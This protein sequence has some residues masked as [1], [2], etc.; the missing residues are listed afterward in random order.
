M[1]AGESGSNE[2]RA[3][4]GTELSKSQ[5][6]LR[7]SQAELAS[8][9]S[10][11]AVDLTRSTSDSKTTAGA[12]LSELTTQNRLALQGADAAARAQF[13]AVLANDD[14]ILA[15]ARGIV[16]TG[17]SEFHDAHRERCSRCYSSSSRSRRC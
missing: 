16:P 6:R 12:K 8:A 1:A 2:A 5:D 17:G 13:D 15:E 3:L 10:A 11:A 7:N 4:A 14:G 9:Q